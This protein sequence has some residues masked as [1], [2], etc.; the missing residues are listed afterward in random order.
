MSLDI[1][2]SGGQ[3]RPTPAKC[4]RS[5]I[6]MCRGPS[7]VDQTVRSPAKTE[8]REHPTKGC[9]RY[10][11]VHAGS[12]T[13]TVFPAVFISRFLLLASGRRR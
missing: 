12:V 11:A 3:S 1:A 9:S 2:L 10:C 7:D 8:I 6:E 4:A 13:A 5:A